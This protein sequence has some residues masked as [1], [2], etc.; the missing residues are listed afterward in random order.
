MS[1]SYFTHNSQMAGFLQ[2]AFM[3]QASKVHLVWKV[4]LARFFT[5]PLQKY[6]LLKQSRNRQCFCS[7]QISNKE[8]SVANSWQGPVE[9]LSAPEP[10]LTPDDDQSVQRCWPFC[11]IHSGG[12]SHIFCWLT[13]ELP[14]P[15]L[16]PQANQTWSFLSVKQ[17][18]IL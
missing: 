9:W 16:T 10:W 6:V 11:M 18:V 17:S 4:A 2:I 3:L 5:P 13:A 15:W 1:S 14:L 8:V 12:A 7:S